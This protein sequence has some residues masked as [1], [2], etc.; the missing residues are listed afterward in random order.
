MFCGGQ[1]SK[2]GVGCFWSWHGR[3]SVQNLCSAMFCCMCGKKLGM[4]CNGLLGPKEYPSGMCFWPKPFF[5]EPHENPDAAIIP[6]RGSSKAT[7]NSRSFITAFFFKSTTLLF[8]SPAPL[9]SGWVMGLPYFLEQEFSVTV[10]YGLLVPGGRGGELALRTPW[11][12]GVLTE[13][14][15]LLSSGLAGWSAF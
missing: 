6:L 9:S 3:H 2:A 4:I 12:F 11:C 10:Q 13:P 8:N 7:G 1:G 14:S 5:L 15:L